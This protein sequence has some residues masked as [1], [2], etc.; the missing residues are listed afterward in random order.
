MSS[1]TKFKPGVEFSRTYLA[2]R[3][4]FEVLG[5]EAYKPS[6]MSFPQLEDSTFFDLLKMGN[7]HDRLSTL[8]W[9]TA[10]TSQ[11]ISE[12]L[13]FFGERLIL[14]RKAASPRAKTF[15]FFFPLE[16]ARR[17]FWGPFFGKETLNALCSWSL[18]LSIPVLGLERVCP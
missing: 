1:P 17:I 14:C 12:D 2:S 6:K 5:L 11:K 3:T 13:F 8:T 10:E 4:Y 16:V 9:K 18:A 7:G 15:F